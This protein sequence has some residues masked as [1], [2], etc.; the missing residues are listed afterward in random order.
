MALSEKDRQV[1]FALLALLSA[2]MAAYVL[3]TLP[4]QDKEASV[5]EFASAVLSSKTAGILMDARGLSAQDARIVY[6]CGTDIASGSLF[7]M[8]RL[9]IIGC[10]S[11][12]K[13]LSAFSDSNSTEKMTYFQAR[14]ALEKIPYIQIR[15]GNSPARFFERHAEIEIDEGYGR[16]CRLNVA[17]TR[18]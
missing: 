16:E 13:C 6:Q 9:Q 14:K 15:K 8:R 11:D 2:A 12:E 17:L 10:E 5:E 7:G 3:L 18:Q 4:A 1:A